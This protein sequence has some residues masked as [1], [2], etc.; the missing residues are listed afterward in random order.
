MDSLTAGS[1]RVLLVCAALLGC[2]RAPEPQAESPAQFC[3]R[4]AALLT[5]PVADSA[6]EAALPMLY[7]C[8]AEA[9]SIIARLWASPPADDRNLRMLVFVGGHIHDGRIYEMVRAV[10]ADIA[11]PRRERLAG[12]FTL[13][14]HYNPHLSVGEQGPYPGVVRGQIAVG[15]S[16]HELLARGTVPLPPNA[17]GAIA[18]FCHRLAADDP[19]P[20]VQYVA[21]ELER[22]LSRYIADSGSP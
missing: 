22:G 21:S 20:E 12:L 18:G 15:W 13:V 7:S 10:A 11:R 19:D 16:A 6:Y 2:A 14:S 17:G 5:P 3:E 8:P 9:G 1:I 4:A